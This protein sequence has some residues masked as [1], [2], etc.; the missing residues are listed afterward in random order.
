MAIGQLPNGIIIQKVKP[1]IWLPSMVVFWAAMTM[2]SAAVKNVTQLCVLRFF[3][4]LAEAS[5]YSG[6]MYI[7]GAWYKPEEIQKRTALFGV[8]G[9]IGTMFAGVMMTAIHKGMRG[10]AGLQGWQWVFII[11][12]YSNLVLEN[13]ADSRRWNYHP[14]DRGVW[15]PLLP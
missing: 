9:Q 10:M 14:A 12:K 2:L 15:L 13:W 1:R 7:I 8:S 11:G 6:A 4:G 3:L 5:T